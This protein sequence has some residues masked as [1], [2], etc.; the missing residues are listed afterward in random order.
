M[1]QESFEIID[2]QLVF[3]SEKELPG[4]DLGAIQSLSAPMMMTLAV[5]NA[6]PST[7]DANRTNGWAHVDQVTQG[8]GSTE[9]E[10]ISTRNFYSCFEY[11]TDGDTSQKISDTNFNAEILD[12]LYPYHCQINNSRPK[13][14]TANEYVEVRMVFG[15]EKDERFDW[16]RFDVYKLDVPEQLGYNLKD[17]NTPPGQTPPNL[18]CNNSVTNING[19][20]VVWT[21]E[22]TDS[23]IKYQRQYSLNGGQS[24]SGNEIYTSKF[25]NFRP[26]GNSAGMDMKV[27]SRVRA[28]YDLNTDGKLNNDEPA[29]DWSNVCDITFDATTPT[30]ELTNPSSGFVNNVVDI[31]ASVQDAN[32]HHYWLAAYKKNGSEIFSKVQNHSESFSDTSIYSWDTTLVEDGEYIIKF[33]ERDAAGNRTSDISVEVTVDNHGP[34]APIISFPGNE[35]YFK[36]APILNQ[37]SS[38]T[39]PAG[40]KEYRVEYVYDDLHD[41]SDAPYRIVTGTSRNHSPGNSEQGGVTI[42]VQAF[43]NLGNE[44]AWS[45]AVHYYY[46]S[47]APDAPTLKSPEDG[48]I[49]QGVKFVQTWEAVAGAVKYNYRSCQNDP[50]TET[51]QLKYSDSYTNPVKTVSAGQPDS[52][53]WWQ[54]QAIDAAGNISPWSDAWEMTIDNTAPEGTIDSVKYS[55]GKVSDK[56]VTNFNTPVIVGTFLSDDVESAVLSVNGHDYSVSINSSDWEATITDAIP[57]GDNELTLTVTDKAGN[58]KSFD[59]NIFIDTKA[60]SATHTY[61]KNG[62][63]VT[64]SI[65]YANNISELTFTGNYEDQTPSAG[66]YWDSFVIFQAQDDGSFRFAA[67]GKKSYCGWRSSPNL[68]NLSGSSFSLAT[69]AP[70]SDCV[71]SLENGEYYLAHQIFDNATRKDIPSINQFRDVLGLHFVIDN[72]IPT[73]AITAPITST[74]NETYIT[75]DWNGY[76]AGTAADVGSHVTEVKLSIKRN[77]G[78]YWDK[79]SASWISDPGNEVLFNADGTNNWTYTLPSH[80]PDTY[81]VRSHAVDAAGNQE[82]TAELV[83]IYD[84]TIPEVKLTINP[85]QADGQNNWYVTKPTVTLDPS[86]ENG[87]KLIEYQWDN[88]SNWTQYTQPIQ[89]PSEGSH[90]LTYRAFDQASNPSKEGVRTILYD[91]TA[92]GQPDISFNQNPTK[93]KEVM[94]MWSASQDNVGIVRY[95]ISWSEKDG[96]RSFSK[97]V[98][99]DVLETEIDE[100]REGKW[101]VKVKA[102]DDAGHST[103]STRTLTV[104]TSAPHAPDLKLDSYVGGTVE[105]SWDKVEDGD[106]YVVLYGTSSG[107]YP[108]AKRVGNVDSVT[109]KDL[110]AGP[111]YFVVKAE[112]KANNVSKASNEV[113]TAPD[114]AVLGTSEVGGADIALVPAAG[115]APT[116]EVLG[117]DTQDEK[118]GNILSGS[119]ES[120]TPGEVLG[121]TDT[122][123][124]NWW[125]LSLII[126]VIMMLITYVMAAESR[127]L[128]IVGNVIATAIASYLL[129]RWLPQPL[130]WIGGLVVLSAI[131]ETLVWL[132]FPGQ[133]VISVTNKPT[134]RFKQ[135]S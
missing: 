81:T 133:A 75:N 46:D 66:L 80:D 113:T 77:N 14:I 125:W 83:I 60:P 50:T 64:D 21:D 32:P 43:D 62:E 51:C 41:F 108:F 65:A 118:A 63:A 93:K 28:F 18:S 94:V 109:I 120:E 92:P 26:F 107:D 127:S 121:A 37:W 69:P 90:L 71:S 10:F 85:D 128:R 55:N 53:F 19:A 76:L 79:D 16:T 36:A 103:E 11:R 22:N 54:V 33:A 1:Y 122:N 88:T 68:I 34:D 100:L 72:T 91:S 49:T 12:G 97:S 56:F 20:S 99:G 35:Q 27:S 30:I 4:S 9:L 61:Y 6:T 2:D 58:S 59:K 7:N 74:T 40:I 104:D 101:T 123:S 17:T 48:F 57:D 126:Y 106:D 124:F 132:K 116:E 134:G 87:I 82:N 13:T 31:R 45:E 52:H 23:N 89:P 78:D 105:L 5:S 47:V 119:D 8:V 84:Q 115:F 15:A 129:Y 39:D 117:D 24:W 38:V 67:N 96:D 130:V 86:D 111:Y 95:D 131:I 73:S 25:T 44:G 42:R 112:D 3:Q 102:Y 29:S 98:G 114:T 70:F 135:N 110:N